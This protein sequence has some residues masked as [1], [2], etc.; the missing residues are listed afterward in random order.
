MKK[1]L[2]IMGLL[3]VIATPAFAQS[4]TP[5][6]G[7]ANIA[8]V[9]TGQDAKSA[10]AQAAPTTDPSPQARIRVQHN[11]GIL[12]GVP[13]GVNPYAYHEGLAASEAN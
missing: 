11:V 3:T 5:E 4:Y 12:E 7:T 9:V 2:T 8:P 1:F 10:F 6:F 13:A